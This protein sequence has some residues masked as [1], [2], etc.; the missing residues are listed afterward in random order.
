MMSQRLGAEEEEESANSSNDETSGK[1]AAKSALVALRKASSSAAKKTYTPSFWRE[2]WGC[3][4]RLGFAVP[5][6]G[7]HV[8][9]G[10]DINHR[11][12]YGCL[13][14]FNVSGGWWSAYMMDQ[15][16]REGGMVEAA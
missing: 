4:F 1:A 8:G 3:V 7:T 16:N 10:V 11:S 5:E 15:R 9:H 2:G 14:P 13:G 12:R 6:R